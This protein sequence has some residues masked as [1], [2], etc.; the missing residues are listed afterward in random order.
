MLSIAVTVDIAA[1]TRCPISAACSTALRGGL[2]GEL[3]E[4]DDVGVLAQRVLEPR[5]RRRGVGAHLTLVD[6]R[7]LVGVQHL[8]RI[9][10]GDDVALAVLV[11]VVDHRGDGRGL[12]RAGEAGHEHE[13]VLLA[14]EVGDRRREAERLEARD[15]GQ[16]PAEHQ[17]H[18]PTLAERARPGSARARR[19]RT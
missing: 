7:A 16:H 9:L 4:H 10:D 1:I 8:D 19:C 11:H 17:A 13:T 6:D 15:A 5:H 12:A 14:C 18:V 3:A 2:V